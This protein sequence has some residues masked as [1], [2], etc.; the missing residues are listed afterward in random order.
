M[1]ADMTWMEF[2][3]GL[4]SALSTFVIAI[5]GWFAKSERTRVLHENEKFKQAADAAKA[6][7]E[8]KEREAETLREE[9]KVNDAHKERII[10]RLELTI[11]EMERRL[12][13]WMDYVESRE[14][15]PVARKKTEE[16]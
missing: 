3:L 2:A 14:E 6:E 10:K 9:R 12:L 16:T 1:F 15:Y 11:V 5:L 13:V 4:F 8:R 7:A